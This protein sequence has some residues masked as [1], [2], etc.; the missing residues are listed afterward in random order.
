MCVREAAIVGHELLQHGAAISHVSIIV[1]F[2]DA[3][4]RYSSRSIERALHRYK[5]RPDEEIKSGATSV[6][7]TSASIG[8]EA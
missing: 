5:R 2:K 4:A 7:R 6:K 1:C 3:I 8:R